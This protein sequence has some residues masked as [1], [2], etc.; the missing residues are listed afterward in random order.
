MNVAGIAPSQLYSLAL[1]L[2]SSMQGAKQ[3]VSE[4]R[5]LLHEIESPAPAADEHEA[6]EVSQQSSERRR[7]QRLWVNLPVLVYGRTIESEPFHEGTEALRVNAGGGLITLT[8]PV[9]CGQRL[10]LINKVNHKEHECHV[11]AERSKY[12]QRTAVVIGFQDPVPDFWTGIDDADS[13]A[14]APQA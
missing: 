13:R 11:V 9:R 2:Q 6:A 4:L 1:E 8:S 10:I 14:I 7:G 5:N 12:L 3:V